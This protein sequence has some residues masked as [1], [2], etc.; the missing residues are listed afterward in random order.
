MSHQP[1]VEDLMAHLENVH[2]CAAATSLR[3]ECAAEVIRR[4]RDAILVPIDGQQVSIDVTS[5]VADLLA[6]RI[7]DF[8]R[9]HD[10]HHA[11]AIAERMVRH[12]QDDEG[13]GEDGR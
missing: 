12:L 10:A 5:E 4:P 11:A 9:L 1:E 2:K 13:S 8:E 6:E 3:Q 7:S